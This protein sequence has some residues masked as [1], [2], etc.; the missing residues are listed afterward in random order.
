MALP[1]GIDGL[2]KIPEAFRPFVSQVDG[3]FILDEGRL[4]AKDKLD[5]FRSNNISLAKERDDLKQLS[6]RYKDIDPDKARAALQRLTQL[7]DQKLID[8]GKLP[9]LVNAKVTEQISAYKNQVEG[10]LSQEQKAK[11]KLAKER[12]ELKQNLAKLLVTD[13]IKRLAIDPKYGI[14]TSSMHFIEKCIEHGDQDGRKWV[15]GDDGAPVAMVGEKP[16]YSAKDPSQKLTKE[17]WL[18]ALIKANDITGKSVGGGAIGNHAGG[19]V[20][21]N[22]SNLSAVERLKAARRGAAA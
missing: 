5:E 10:Q 13:S 19:A 21:K 11:E 18:E 15:L 7:D 8:A 1:L 6:E 3:K 4:V 9:E 22:V 2:D 14:K 20:L 16:A 12:D 17:E